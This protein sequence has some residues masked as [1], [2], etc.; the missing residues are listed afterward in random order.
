[1]KHTADDAGHGRGN[2][3]KR[4]E[5]NHAILVKRVVHKG[6]VGGAF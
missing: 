4:F 3:P 2:H 6:I 5:H 1:V